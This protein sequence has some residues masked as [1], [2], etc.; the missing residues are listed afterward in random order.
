METPFLLAVMGPTAS[1]K[2]ELAEAL[3]KGYGAQLINADA[4]QVYRGLD[5]G[6]GKPEHK[7]RYL[8]LDFIDPQEQFGL[9]R[10]VQ[11]AH[12]ALDELWKQGRSSI[13][14]GGTGLY[15]R[16]LMEEYAQMSEKPDEAIRAR[17]IE[18]EQEIGSVALFAE[19]EKQHPEVAARVAASNPLRVR[20]AWERVLSPPA[21]PVQ[22]PPF[23]K[24]KIGLSP[25]VELL[26]ERISQRIDRMLQAGWLDEVKCLTASGVALDAPGFKAIGYRTFAEH[27]AGDKSLE[28][29]VALVKVATQQYAKR[30]RTWL[31]SEPAIQ[32]IEWHESPKDNF[33]EAARLINTEWTR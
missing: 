26:R 28:E 23:K 10:W 9:G 17:I 12:Q 27:L 5:I 29:A 16:A 33:L 32:L 14:V 1:G 18:R 30:Q 3:A 22:L 20:R 19:L 7:D 24:M 8:L 2:T 21:E 31:R 11:L 25:P 6:T 15:V 4:F 13:L